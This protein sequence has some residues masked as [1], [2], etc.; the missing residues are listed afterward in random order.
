MS[1]PTCRPSG[2]VLHGSSADLAGRW[3]DEHVLTGSI[4]STWAVLG[5]A[6]SGASTYSRLKVQRIPLVRAKLPDGGAIVGVRVRHERL[7]EVRYVLSAL[8]DAKTKTT[9]ENKDLRAIGC[10]FPTPACKICYCTCNSMCPPKRCL[11]S[12]VEHPFGVLGPCRKRNQLGVRKLSAELEAF[13]RTQPN[14][15]AAWRNWAGAH[16]VL[17]G[18]W[19]DT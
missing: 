11:L 10:T 8:H 12:L 15:S 9:S 16:Q 14:Q 2:S 6:I 7:Q 3:E 18:Q 5:T 19:A 4:L 17:N 13:L 1:S